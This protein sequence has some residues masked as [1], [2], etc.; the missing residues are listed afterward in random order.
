[1]KSIKER[2]AK[3]FGRAATPSYKDDL[4]EPSTAA[5]RPELLGTTSLSTANN[6]L[7]AVLKLVAPYWTKSSTKEKLIAWP[8]LLGAVGATVWQ[9]DILVQFS[10]WQGG[11]FDL[12]QNIFETMKNNKA[13]LADPE[14]LAQVPELIAHKA[15]IMPAVK[16]FGVIVG[17]FMASVALSFSLAQFTA[18]RW[19]KW[20]T[21]QYN[22]DWLSKNAFYR[23]PSM[24]GNVENPDQ[25]IQEDI[26]KFTGGTMSLATDAVG[27]VLGLVTF[28]TLLW[29]MSGS[30]NIAALGGPDMV[31]PGF[32]FWLAA[33][34]AAAWTGIT[35]AMGKPLVNLDRQQQMREAFFR[36]DLKRVSENAESIALNGGAEVEKEILKKSFNN[37]MINAKDIIMK[38]KQLVLSRALYGNL[39]IV[40]PYTAATPMIW[41]GKI[42]TFGALQ[43]TAY[44]FGQVQSSLSWFIDNYQSLADLGATTIRLSSLTSAIDQSNADIDHKN[45]IL[46][47]AQPALAAP[48][49]STGPSVS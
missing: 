29:N 42:S 39:S 8:M 15:K 46:K 6:G 17:K 25:R 14:Q 22:N 20:M 26:N 1:M 4:M 5:T 27:S 38:R 32:M 47:D 49:G 36:S 9:V 35:H 7:R 2:L 33:G 41:T 28:S 12:F 30:F 18:L 3:V 16:D 23:L 19:R 13:L 11:F 40:V 31:I 43:Q 44:Y 24:Y 37:V 34:Y 21:D 48:S 45:Q 10:Q